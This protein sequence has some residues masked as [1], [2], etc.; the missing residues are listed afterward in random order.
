MKL[1]NIILSLSITIVVTWMIMRSRSEK[2]TADKDKLL[3]AVK[4]FI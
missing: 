2:Y 3:K 4:K 1:N